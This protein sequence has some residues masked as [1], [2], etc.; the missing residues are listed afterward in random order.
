[1][2]AKI[3]SRFYSA[4][5]VSILNAAVA[6]VFYFAFRQGRS[7]LGYFG[8]NEFEWLLA[9]VVFFAI[10]ESIAL[11]LVALSKILTPLTGVNSA[12]GRAALL[13]ALFILN[14]L[15]W[16]YYALSNI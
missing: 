5:F 9:Y 8:A 4:E 7:L 10:F 6:T 14:C 11:A 2:A 3:N 12:D 1:M 13:L 15:S 16:F